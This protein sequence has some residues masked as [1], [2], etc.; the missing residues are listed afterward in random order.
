MSRTQ[1]LFDLL[2]LLRRHQYPVAASFLASEL[3]VSVRTIYRDIATLQAQG[4]EI[5]GEAGIGYVL[6]PS[7]MLPPLMFSQDELEV[8][9]LGAEWVTQRADRDMAEAAQNAIAKISSVLPDN[10]KHQLSKDVTRVVPV[11]DFS[12]LQ[13][14]LTDIRSSIRHES[15]AE[16]CY[17]DEK[18]NQ[19]QRRI[20]PVLIGFFE[21][22]YVLTAWCESRNAFRHFRVDRMQSF[23][24]TEEKYPRRQRE[25]LKSWQQQEGVTERDTRY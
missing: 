7:F 12:E 2:Q 19:T 24:R 6:K 21:R 8:L 4:A 11:G 14:D 23:T 16:I 18:G 10:L 1:R 9:L 20:W 25:L 5:E 17:T 13:V 22:C 15:V 3:G